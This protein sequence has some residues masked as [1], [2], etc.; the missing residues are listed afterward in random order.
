MGRGD[1][2][3]EIEILPVVIGAQK[4]GG[5]LLAHFGCD[6]AWTLLFLWMLPLRLL[7]GVGIPNV[8]EA[9]QN[10]VE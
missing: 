2:I 7:P 6:A 3:T 5:L 1:A 8:W 10:G 4:R 9:R